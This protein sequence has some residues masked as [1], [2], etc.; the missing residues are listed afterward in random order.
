MFTET[1]VPTTAT[2][3]NTPEDTRQLAF[4][5]CILR[6][7]ELE[8]KSKCRLSCR[9]FEWFFSVTRVNCDVLL[10]NS[11][12][13]SLRHFI[14]IPQLKITALIN[15]T[16]PMGSA[17]IRQAAVAL[18]QAVRVCQRDEVGNPPGGT[19]EDHRQGAAPTAA[20]L[21]CGTD[22]ERLDQQIRV[23]A[24]VQTG[25]VVIRT[26]RPDKPRH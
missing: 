5:L 15:D 25:C 21:A 10:Y 26:N 3:C 20:A 11:L 23:R 24:S 13:H 19:R 17:N 2:L 8:S 18:L 7:P 12:V 1:L 6:G 14:F 4:L 16:E 9:S 22:Q